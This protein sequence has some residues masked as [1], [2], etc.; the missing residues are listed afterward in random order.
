MKPALRAK[1]TRSPPA[2]FDMMIARFIARASSAIER[3]AA[4]S[5]MRRQGTE[6]TWLP[7]PDHWMTVS[8]TRPVTS[9]SITRGSSSASAIPSA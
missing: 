3:T 7:T 1:R 5:C 6:I 4:S 9:D 8:A 2:V